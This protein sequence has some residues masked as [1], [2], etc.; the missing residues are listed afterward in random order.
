MAKKRIINLGFGTN[1]EAVNLS[2]LAPHETGQIDGVYEVGLN[3]YQLVQCV[4]AGPS[5]AGDL[6][7]VKIG[8]LAHQPGQCTRTFNAGTGPSNLVYGVFTTAVTLNYYT[9]IKQ[10]GITLCKTK[11]ADVG[12]ANIAV[13]GD[14]AGSN[15]IMTNVA[16][17]IPIG[18]S[19]EAKD[20]TSAGF[21]TCFMRIASY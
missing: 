17:S 9:L 8:S 13:T 10:R 18:V 20:A 21:T 3:G 14:S 6:G 19:L 2:A 5:V 16:G 1:P 11:G 12:A 7:Y 4:D 15:Q